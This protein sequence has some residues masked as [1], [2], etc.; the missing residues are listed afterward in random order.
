MSDARMIVAVAIVMM[1]SS[2]ISD[3]VLA[4]AM[5]MVMVR[6]STSFMLYL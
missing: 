5:A 6:P 2:V 4:L 1:R 3:D